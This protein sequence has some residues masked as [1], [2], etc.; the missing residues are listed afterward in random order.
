MNRWESFSTKLVKILVHILDREITADEG[1]I[2]ES[3]RSSKFFQGA[4]RFSLAQIVEKPFCCQSLMY[5]KTTDAPLRLKPDDGPQIRPS[6]QS[7]R[8]RLNA[9]FEPTSSI[10][11]TESRQGNSTGASNAKERGPGTRS[12]G[13]VHTLSSKLVPI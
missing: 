12:P 5:E 13:A 3:V 6:R 7:C 4:C 8:L 2:D 9:S 10:A 11:S 1:T